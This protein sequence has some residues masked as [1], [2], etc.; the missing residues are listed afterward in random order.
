MPR[1]KYDCSNPYNLLFWEIGLFKTN[2][3]DFLYDFRY[4]YK[5]IIDYFGD[6]LEERANEIQS[7]IDIIS[8][9]NVEPKCKNRCYIITD[10][11][12]VVFAAVDQ[13]EAVFDNLVNTFF[14]LDDLCRGNIPERVNM[15]Y[16]TEMY[17]FRGKE[18]CKVQY[19]STLQL[20]QF[21]AAFHKENI[22]DFQGCRDDWYAKP[23]RE[24]KRK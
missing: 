21:M 18:L 6:Y 24:A 4:I 22:I 10:I 7:K 12:H 19:L 14:L 15:S 11:D 5:N 17:L 23:R 8:N 3:T 2:Y 1:A 9:V 16:V 13:D 20:A